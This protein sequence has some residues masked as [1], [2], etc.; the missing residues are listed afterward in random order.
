MRNPA[1][2]GPT[3]GSPRGAASFSGALGRVTQLTHELTHD[4]AQAIPKS[5]RLDIT[6]VPDWQRRATRLGL[7]MLFFG[8]L[9]HC[10]QWSPEQHTL[11]DNFQKSCNW[12]AITC[13]VVTAPLIGK[14]AQVAFDRLLGTLVGG[15]VAY[16]AFTIGYHL[17]SHRAAGVFIS[18]G[19]ATT[20]VATTYL[21]YKKS[22]DQLARFVQLTYVIVAYGAKPEKGAFLLALMRVGG[23]FA[24]GLFGVLLAV[25]VLPRSASIEALREMRKALREL[26]DLNREVWSMGG[27][28][29]EK[30]GQHHFRKHH[31]HGYSGMLGG[32][33]QGAAGGAPPSPWG[34]S[35]DLVHSASDP[36]LAPR[37]PGL[38]AGGAGELSSEALDLLAVVADRDEELDKREAAIE[39]LFTALYGTLGRVDEH[40]GQIKGEV[41]VWHCWGHYF[42]LPGVHWWPVRGRW[43]V[44]K[45][46]LEQ[47]ATCLRRVARMLWTLLLD[48][49]EG[50]GS[51]MEDVL[52]LC[53]PKQLLSELATYQSAAILDLLKAFPNET[54]IEVDNLL[55]LGQ[56]TDCL[57]QISDHRAREAVFSVK[58]R[59]ATTT[60]AKSGTVRSAATAAAAA[61][62][63]VTLAAAGTGGGGGDVSVRLER[64]EEA[65][66]RGGL[67]RG[68]SGLVPLADVSTRSGRTSLADRSVSGGGGGG[69]GGRSSLAVF[70][71]AAAADY[72]IVAA[73]AKAES[74]STPLLGRQPT[75]TSTAAGGAAS[76][77]AA[78]N[79]NGSA[80]GGGG[81]ALARS[82]TQSISTAASGGGGGGNGGGGKDGHVFISRLLSGKPGAHVSMAL[83][84]R[85]HRQVQAA[86]AAAG[87]AAAAA[88]SAAAA[89]AGPGEA[90]AEGDAAGASEGRDASARAGCVAAASLVSREGSVASDRSGPVASGRPSGVSGP[91]GLGGATSGHP[92][93]RSE[94]IDI[95]DG[96]TF[97]SAQ[98]PTAG[99]GSEPAAAVGAVPCGP[100]G[101]SAALPPLPPV[102][103]SGGSMHRRTALPTIPSEPDL[104]SLCSV[105]DLVKVHDA[106]DRMSHAGPGAS[107]FVS[108]T[109]RGS[110]STDGPPAVQPTAT[111]AVTAGAVP[112][113]AAAAAAAATAAAAALSPF[114][115]LARARGSPG[116]S[117]RPS[118][119]GVPTAAP[120]TARPSLDGYH[121]PAAGASPLGGGT[122][123]GGT[124]GAGGGGGTAGGGGG[125]AGAPAAGSAP[126]VTSTVPS[127]A[128]SLA[129]AAASAAALLGR[130][131]LVRASTDGEGP[132]GAGQGGEQVMFPPTEAGYLA[133]VRWYSFQF[134]MDEMVNELEEAFYAC[135]AV[136]RQLPYPIG[137][138]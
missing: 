83:P 137:G 48:F 41:Y 100:F 3:G 36:G 112:S 21:A 6:K 10:L 102:S 64:A 89:A 26:H 53:Y 69:G 95:F 138:S 106:A 120:S 99:S 4:I 115:P 92:I 127:P 20:V 60:T 90:G 45:H 119:D 14:V 82:G 114:H 18:C 85:R 9:G 58:R 80:S 77:T 66:T 5:I 46:D 35:P 75:S 118:L 37:K 33:R 128:P 29:G 134:V 105:S 136:L 116:S 129:L 86:A 131:A 38:R 25:A 93:G 7:A 67:Q 72:A 49:E 12:A 70:A 97:A 50:F 101:S 79:G 96:F 65:S 24:G 31:R 61:A 28:L 17:F 74:E 8:L 88:E 63:A 126:A 51:E 91:T 56:V 104:A 135:A 22:M 44:P 122:G 123:G 98:P 68:V 113:A 39:R 81:L 71:A 125:T 16:I 109:Q 43:Q 1:S 27:M 2:A 133:Q 59:R 32:R 54:T 121:A 52:R 73:A 55:T 76:S 132:G 19:A 110:P 11:A 107:P 94:T 78:A 62:A 57:L 124:G 40:L 103:A 130:E 42:F 34:S 111:P 87:S 47:M 15:G 13:I 30:H 108:E 117:S 23:I 84:P